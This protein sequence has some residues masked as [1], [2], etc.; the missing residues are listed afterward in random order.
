L[1]N[2]F[3]ISTRMAAGQF[4]N[5]GVG[6]GG[7]PKVVRV[8]KYELNSSVVFLCAFLLEKTEIKKG[9]TGNFERSKIT[10]SERELLQLLMFIYWPVCNV[11]CV[12]VA[13][14]S[15]SLFTNVVTTFAPMPHVFSPSKTSESGGLCTPPWSRA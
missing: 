1:H 11:V 8:Q 10:S 5:R 7:E 14:S 3:S 12:C 13:R 4:C 9:E 6:K 2:I 15:P